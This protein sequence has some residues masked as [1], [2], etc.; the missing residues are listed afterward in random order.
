MGVFLN[1]HWTT[2]FDRIFHVLKSTNNQPILNVLFKLVR[3]NLGRFY[4]Y[5]Y[6]YI[7]LVVTDC[8]NN[9]I[10]FINSHRMFLREQFVFSRPGLPRFG[11]IFGNVDNE[12]QMRQTKG[13]KTWIYP[14]YYYKFIQLYGIFTTLEHFWAL[15]S[16]NLAFFLRLRAF[17]KWFALIGTHYKLKQGTSCQ[18]A[19]IYWHRP[20]F[21]NNH[22][23]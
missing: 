11:P 1:S 13:L 18:V 21:L 9:K 10:D 16:P 5:I 15:K 12:F 17:W 19:P 23:F 2:R 3:L 4:I 6:V 22:F 7:D 20:F 14:Y 8:Q